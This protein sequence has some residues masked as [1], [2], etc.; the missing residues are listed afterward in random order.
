MRPFEMI[1]VAGAALVV[2]GPAGRTAVPGPSTEFPE[3]SIVRRH[4]P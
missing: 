3:V 1:M 2:A 4:V